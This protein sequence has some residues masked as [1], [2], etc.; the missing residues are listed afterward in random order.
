MMVNSNFAKETI[1]FVIFS[2]PIY[3][4]SDDFPIKL[5]FNKLL[6][7]QENLINLK[8]L[9]QQIDPSEFTEIVNK[10]YII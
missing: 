6:E 2:T 4:H 1:E 7:I 3:L 10:A 8:T 9:F 5:S